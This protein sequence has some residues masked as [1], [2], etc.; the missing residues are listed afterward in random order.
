MDHLRLSQPLRLSD[1]YEVFDAT[2]ACVDRGSQRVI[3][4]R[5]LTAGGS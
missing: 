4:G 5:D 2:G 3:G 1:R